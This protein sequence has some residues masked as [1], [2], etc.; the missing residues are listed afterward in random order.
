MIDETTLSRALQAGC[1]IL[2]Q[3]S[4][5]VWS[6]ETSLTYPLANDGETLVEVRI[7][8]PKR[9]DTLFIA[10]VVKD[11]AGVWKNRFDSFSVRT[12]QPSSDYV[13]PT[14]SSGD[15]RGIVWSEVSDESL[16]VAAFYADYFH[17]AFCTFPKLGGRCDRWIAAPQAFNTPDAIAF[18]STAEPRSILFGMLGYANGSGRL[19]GLVRASDGKLLWSGTL[20]HPGV[21]PLLAESGTGWSPKNLDVWRAV[22][23]DIALG[24]DENIFDQIT[25]M[26]V[27]DLD[28]KSVIRIQ[29][30]LPDTVRERTRWELIRWKL[31]SFIDF[32]G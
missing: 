18:T 20:L 7:N 17:L 16:V 4:K 1:W 23:R 13:F 2:N 19:A 30:Q 24:G 28:L 29:E 31:K 11:R 12:G 15:F 6:A 9:L 3:K 10:I 8:R 21:I 22:S 27:D 25:R 26:Q 32:R 14:P 5:G